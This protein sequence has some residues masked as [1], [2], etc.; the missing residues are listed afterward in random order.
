MAA[1]PLIAI[2]HRPGEEFFVKPQAS[3][4]APSPVALDMC[5]LVYESMC[6]LENLR[7][8]RQEHQNMYLCETSE[9]ARI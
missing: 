2:P 6:A 8:R 1:G 7:S 5:V 4:A 3:Y 9:S